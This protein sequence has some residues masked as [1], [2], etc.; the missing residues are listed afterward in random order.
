MR[1]S[2]AGYVIK[3]AGGVVSYKSYRQR[4]VTLSSTE[5]EYIALTYAAKEI[6]W[7]QRLLSQLGYQGHDLRP[8]HLQTDNVTVIGSLRET[9]LIVEAGLPGGYLPARV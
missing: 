1:K 2:S 6:A 5:S 3:M 8:F 7:L 4:L 9:A